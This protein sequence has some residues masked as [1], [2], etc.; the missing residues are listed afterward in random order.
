MIVAIIIIKCNDHNNNN[1][2]RNSI[3]NNTFNDNI[4][5]MIIGTTRREIS[6]NLN[7]KIIDKIFVAGYACPSPQSLL[8]LN[9]HTMLHKS[10][11][12]ISCS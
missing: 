7:F 3:N 1:K 9:F 8:F 4:V 10:L 12:V 5:A 2:N 6:Y 11:L